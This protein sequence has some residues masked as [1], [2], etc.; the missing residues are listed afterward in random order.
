[1]ASGVDSLRMLLGAETWTGIL[2]RVSRWLFFAVVLALLPIAF[3]GMSAVTRVDE[4]FR[5]D[6][7]LQHGE[8]LLVTAAV[9]GASLADLFGAA[10]S[11]FRTL[12]F[13]AGCFG[14]VVILAA[15]GWF[16]DI[17][18]AIRDGSQVDSHAVAVGSLW[19]FAFALV[20]GSTCVIVAAVSES[21]GRAVGPSE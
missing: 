10:G 9:S 16:A 2:F 6:D 3:G 5:L 12:R 19:L 8:L 21:L 13:T 18:A 15:A 1:M 7:L 17:A 4:A 14:G 11:H 20:S